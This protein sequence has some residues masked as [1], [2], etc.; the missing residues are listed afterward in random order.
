MILAVH[1]LVLTLHYTSPW[2]LVFLAVH[3][4]MSTLQCAPMGSGVSCCPKLNVDF[5]KCTHG[6]RSVWLSMTQC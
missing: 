5:T 2:G 1:V 3:D 6:A 4:S